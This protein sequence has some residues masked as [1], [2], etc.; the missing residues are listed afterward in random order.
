MPDAMLRLTNNAATMPENKR[1]DFM[2]KLLLAWVMWFAICGVAMAAVNINTA[3]KEE[4]T[5]LKGI[6]DKRAQD[7]IDYRTKNGPFK[8]VDD[9]GKVPGIGP[10]TMKQIRSELTTT[11]KTVLDKPAATGTKSK[12]SDS[13]KAAKSET[14]KAETAKG[15]AMKAETKAT[16]TK[17]AK[18]A[19]AKKT[20]PAKGDAAKAE[21]AKDKVAE[22]SKADDKTKAT[23][24]ADEKKAENK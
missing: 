22:K 23:A 17:T 6:G 20:E 19:D 13:T 9:L 21:K 4:L 14:K 16:D 12:A 1:R 11:G 18:T 5:S 2:K 8:S 15:D 24:K 10:G 7:I 3:T